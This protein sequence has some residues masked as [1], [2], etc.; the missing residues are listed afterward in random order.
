MSSVT[1]SGAQS[2][3]R[4]I[5]ALILAIIGVVLIVVGIIYVS[6]TA[7]SLPGFIPGH[8]A[9]SSGHHPLRAGSSFIVGLILLAV[10]WRAGFGGKSGSRSSG[11]N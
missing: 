7:S 9:G 5:S 8:I 3:V 6:T 4:R 2:S 11:R 1:H 10:A